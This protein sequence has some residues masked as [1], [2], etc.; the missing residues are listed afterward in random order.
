MTNEV[1]TNDK[2]VH[3]SFAIFHFF[4]GSLGLGENNPLNKPFFG[5]GVAPAEGGPAF[6]AA[7]GAGGGAAGGGF[8][9]NRSA[10]RLVN[11]ARGGGGGGLGGANRARTPHPI[12]N[13]T[14]IEKKAMAFGALPA[15]TYKRKT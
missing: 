12:N 13:V 14:R 7:A 2:F 6:G 10:I 8:F 15:Q 11:P 9:L 4:G 5:G 1:M 3:L